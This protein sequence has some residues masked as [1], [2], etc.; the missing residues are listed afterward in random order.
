MIEITT[1]SYWISITNK[2]KWINLQVNKNNPTAIR[3]ADTPRIGFQRSSRRNK[4]NAT[5]KSIQLDLAM[6]Y[7][8]T[9]IYS[10]A[11]LDSPEL[12]N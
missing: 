7:K 3:V 6:V 9:V 2:I 1:D 11:Q 4:E 5:I 8:L 10:K 12:S